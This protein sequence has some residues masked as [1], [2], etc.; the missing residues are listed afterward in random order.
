MAGALDTIATDGLTLQAGPGTGS[1]LGIDL[2]HSESSLSE[3]A[4]AILSGSEGM[5]GALREVAYQLRDT[6]A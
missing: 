6:A 4:G 1:G 3:I 2:G 5:Q